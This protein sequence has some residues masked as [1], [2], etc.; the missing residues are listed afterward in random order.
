MGSS[1]LIASIK[2]EIEE[3]TGL[4]WH[5]VLLRVVLGF[6]FATWIGFLPIYFIIHY[7]LDLNFF[8]YDLFNDGLFGINAFVFVAGALSLL[9]SFALWG[10]VPLGWSSYKHK[11]ATGNSNE[12]RLQTWI[13]VFVGII[14]HV[15]LIIGS[16]RSDKFSIYMTFSV[17]GFLICICMCSFVGQ[18]Y[19]DK[20]LNWIPSCIFVFFTAMFPILSQ[21]TNTQIVKLGLNAFRIGGGVGVK[22]LSADDLK[23]LGEGSLILQTPENLYI[24]SKNNELVIVPYSQRTIVKIGG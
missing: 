9:L 14:F 4:S 3:K 15:F 12:N 11:K 17:V 5:K 6:L 18:S 21:E 19:K 23:V 20:L 13:F 2:N 1:K 8:S 10:A 16:V 24:E 22:A 7:M